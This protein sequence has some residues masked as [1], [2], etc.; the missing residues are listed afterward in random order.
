MLSTLFRTFCKVCRVYYSR[1]RDILLIPVCPGPYFF[2]SCNLVG[3]GEGTTPA[4][5][6]A[7][8]TGTLVS[9]LHRL[10]DTDGQDG[11]FFVFG[12]L[13]VKVEGRF[14]LLFSLHE[15]RNDHACFL[16]SILS[17]PFVVHSAKAFSGM[18]EST[19]LTRTFSDQGVRL[20]LRKEPRSLLKKRGPASHDYLPRH[21][22]KG[23]GRSHAGELS[24][25]GES[26]SQTQA[27]L[28]GAMYHQ[29][30]SPTFDPRPQ[31]G[32]GYSYQSSDSFSPT[33][34]DEPMIKRPRTASDHG[35]VPPF[36]Q[37][38]Q[39]PDNTQYNSPRINTE[40]PQHHYGGYTQSPSQHQVFASGYNYTQSPQSLTDARHTY[41]SSR[42]QNTQ[43]EMPSY[44]TLDDRQPQTFYSPSQ[45]TFQ[46]YNVPPQMGLPTPPIPTRT[47][48]TGVFGTQDR[49]QFLPSMGTPTAVYGRMSSSN[50]IPVGPGSTDMYQT[51]GTS[52]PTGL[53]MVPGTSGAPITTTGG[54]TMP[55]Y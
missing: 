54:S 29:T 46:Q 47:V 27:E 43:Q 52:Y 5:V 18:S 26:S 24:T 49:T 6:G 53:N 28:Q 39:L 14:R 20:R 19:F 22:N 15:M 44:N 10:K 4:S 2:M 1:T 34:S 13:S 16:K 25:T 21:Y 51:Q 32:R 41:F 9:S 17:N 7:S 37:T 31:I 12:D 48:P 33:F 11:A 45:P 30:Q 23:G 36:V 8:L 50:Y 42:L 35:Q 40:I 3:I 55:P 38:Q